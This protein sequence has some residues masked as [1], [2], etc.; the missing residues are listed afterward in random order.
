[1]LCIYRI[2]R[3]KT[4]R[5]LVCGSYK[6]NAVAQ[7]VYSAGGTVHRQST[8]VA[9]AVISEGCH[10]SALI[11]TPRLHRLRERVTRSWCA[12]GDHQFDIRIDPSAFASPTA[13]KDIT[14]GS[15][16]ETVLSND[17]PIFTLG[18][19]ASGASSDTS[20]EYLGVYGRAN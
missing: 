15:V 12:Q 10:K 4:I 6:R 16:R 5:A 17:P 1:M 9:G 3:S 18:N 11:Q 7:A 19:Y 13:E 20:P 8:G 2:V 14:T